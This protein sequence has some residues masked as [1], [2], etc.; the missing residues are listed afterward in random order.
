M[1]QEQSLIPSTVGEWTAFEDQRFDADSIF[2]YIDGAGEVY[3]SYN[4]KSLFSRRFRAPGKPDLVVD[5]FDMGRAADAFGVFT[6]DLEG[7]EAGIGQG[8]TYKGGLL[9]FW[10]GRYFVS[11]YAEE[12]NEESRSSVFALG[13]KIDK[14]IRETGCKPDLLVRLPRAELDVRTIRFFHN[15]SVLN[16]HYFVADR[17]ILGLDQRTDAVLGFYGKAPV[18]T[19]LLLVCYPD[20]VEASKGL[21]EFL[22]FRGGGDAVMEGDDMTWTGAVRK[23]N[24]LAV[25]FK[26]PSR[27]FAQELLQKSVP[28]GRS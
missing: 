13:R 22:R 24:F 1:A 15:H 8:S 26:A 21:E 2:R 12:E 6:H 20:A 17:N 3:R 23:E 25:V 19:A 10:K 28:S 4:M 5:L 14:A 9:S 7:G 16:F 27:S 18:R 11:V